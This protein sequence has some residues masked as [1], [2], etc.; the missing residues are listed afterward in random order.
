M[1]FIQQEQISFIVK[2]CW[3]AKKLKNNKRN[4][5][6]K[7]RSNIVIYL[8]FHESKI[9]KRVRREVEKLSNVFTGKIIKALRICV[10]FI[11]SCENLVQNR[12]SECIS[13]RKKEL[14]KTFIQNLKQ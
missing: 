12:L 4:L 7:L 5:R 3:C 10:L 13:I 11:S 2:I 6:N 1:S 14:L 8:L 9:V